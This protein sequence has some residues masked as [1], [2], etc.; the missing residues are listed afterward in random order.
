MNCH[1]DGQGLA[2]QG[3]RTVFCGQWGG[4]TN[5]V[6][7]L[8]VERAQ[9]QWCSET[10]LYQ[11]ARVIVN[12]IFIRRLILHLKSAMVGMPASQ[13]QAN[14]TKQVFSTVVVKHLPAHTGHACV[15]VHTYIELLTNHKEAQ[16]QQ[17]KRMPG[18]TM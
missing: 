4:G 1:T 2:M 9:E 18:R 3:T 12:I 7:W 11:V 14:V 5:K 13:K 8:N 6:N 10:G 17:K 15:C 16:Q